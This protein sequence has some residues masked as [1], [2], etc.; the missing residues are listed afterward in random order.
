MGAV[1]CSRRATPRPRA[2]DGGQGRLGLALGCL[3]LVAMPLPAATSLPGGAP[4]G[5]MVLIVATPF[6]FM[7]ARARRAPFDAVANRAATVVLGSVGFLILWS[8]LSAFGSDSPLRAIRYLASLVTAFA[9]YFLIRATLTRARLL[10][11][12]DLL[13]GTLAATCILSLVAYR[14][15]GLHEM[16]FNGT[17][18]AAGLFKNSNQFGMA[19]STTLP[20]ALALTLAE[21]RRRVFRATCILLLLLGLV[22]SGS[23]TNL[24]LVSGSTVA[25][26][27]AQAFI[28]NA[29]VR[30]LL[31]LTL[32]LVGLVIVAHLGLLT[33][34]F[35]NPRALTILT[36][37]LSSDADVASLTTRSFLWSYSI[38]QFL[39]HPVLGQGAGQPIDIFYREEDVS[40]SHNMLLDYLR[41]LGAPGFAGLVVVAGTVAAVAAGTIAAAA[42]VPVDLASRMICIGLSISCLSYLAANMTSDSFGPTTSSFFWVFAWLLF[43]ARRMLASRAAAPMQ[44]ALPEDRDLA[45]GPRLEF[46]R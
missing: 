17:D 23:K 5:L 8:C 22:A 31:M 26:L 11:Y 27:G 20:A 14:V 24:L 41:S 34:N 3:Y 1:A 37:F 21:P 2:P 16:V 45:P 35:L 10:L 32:S 33:L 29:G 36:S 9:V 15:D 38:D 7:T 28:A 43:A 39:A 42:S 4:L 19:I 30:R 6:W 25:I 13:T 12:V 40:H 46:T 18:R 44:S